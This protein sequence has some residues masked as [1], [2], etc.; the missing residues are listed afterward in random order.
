[1]INSHRF[2]PRQVHSSNWARHFI[3]NALVLVSTRNGL[4]TVEISL[5]FVLKSSNFNQYTPDAV[6]AC[7][8]YQHIFWLHS[9]FKLSTGKR[10]Q[11]PHCF[12]FKFVFVVMCF[13]ISC[14]Q[15]CC[16]SKVEYM[17]KLKHCY[18][19]VLF[20]YWLRKQCIL[21]LKYS[22]RPH[23]SNLWYF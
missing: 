10:I 21:T 20:V 7:E 18:I 5:R 6:F 16:S 4:D 1:M 12:M 17:V 13:C 2:E 19:R 9:H 23:Q 11:I 8:I 15:T 22:I 14:L 3:H